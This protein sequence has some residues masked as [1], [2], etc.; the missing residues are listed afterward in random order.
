MVPVPVPVPEP[1]APE[2][3][4]PASVPESP[5][6][7]PLAEALATMVVLSDLFSDPPP[8]PLHHSIDLGNRNA[9]VERGPGVFEVIVPEGM[10]EPTLFDVGF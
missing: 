10:A 7:F 1:V 2:T 6:S 4:A 5:E 8:A 3:D 9:V